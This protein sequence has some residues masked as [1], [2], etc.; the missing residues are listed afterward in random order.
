MTWNFPREDDSMPETILLLQ[1]SAWKAAIVQELL[2]QS[3]EGPFVVEWL[4]SYTAGVERL[5]DQV[6]NSIAAVLVDLST[7]DGQEL[8]TFAQIFQASPHIP[9]LVLSN[10]E[11]EEVAKQ[12]VQHGAQDYILDDRLDSHSLS[13]ALRNMI[14]RAANAEASF[15]EKERAQVTLN[16]IGDAVIST[17]AAGS[18]TYLNQVA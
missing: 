5:N 4:R 2:A 10:P 15:V 8:E 18:V 11:H 13:K 16:S 12:A 9:I 6:K 7:P 14:E 17:D 3:S 1:D